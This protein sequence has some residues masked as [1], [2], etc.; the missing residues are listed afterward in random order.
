MRTSFLGVRQ[1]IY[2]VHSDIH[3]S[4]I[5]FDPPSIV[6]EIKAKVNKWDLIKL[7]AFAQQRK[8]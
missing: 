3:H 8:Q 6:M 1:K 5:L 2:A 7:K 4:K